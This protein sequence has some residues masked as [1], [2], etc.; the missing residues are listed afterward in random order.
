MEHTE[1]S[2]A[3]S[4]VFNVLLV[5]VLIW[6]ILLRNQFGSQITPPDEPIQRQQ[7]PPLIVVINAPQSATR[8]LPLVVPIKPKKCYNKAITQLLART[9]RSLDNKMGLKGTL[10]N[11][12][13]ILLGFWHLWE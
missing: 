13:N 6:A 1:R 9:Q 5:L 3:L 10:W 4:V 2:H 8:M 7:S 12:K 11:S